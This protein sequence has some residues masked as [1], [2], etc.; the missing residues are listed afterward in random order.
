MEIINFDDVQEFLDQNTSPR[1]LLLG[2]GFSVACRPDIF[3]YRSLYDRVKESSGD[4]VE[5]AFDVLETHDFEAVIKFL[6]Q[7][8]LFQP[9]VHHECKEL[10]EQSQESAE[11]LK[12]LLISMIAVNHP[13]FPAEILDDEYESC[14]KFLSPFVSSRRPSA[15]IYTLNYDLLLYWTI[16]YS[17]DKSRRIFQADDGFRSPPEEHEQKYLEWSVKGGNQQRVHYLHGALHLLTSQ[18]RVLKYAW[19]RTGIRLLTQIE[20]ALNEDRF[21]L[22]V[23]E[24]D[25]TGKEE[26][27]IRN[28]YLHR[29]FRSFSSSLDKSDASLV[30]YGWSFSE[31][32]AHIKRV[33][34]NSSLKTI[35]ISVYGSPDSEENRM[36]FERVRQVQA[37]RESKENSVPLS[38]NYFNAESANIWGERPD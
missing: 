7:L 16:M 1:Y 12:E 4:F 24:G 10:G 35:F 30:T 3:N 33:I 26:K 18:T 38:V 17:L 20:A 29:A 37:W 13:E 28:A 11:R 36:L 5:D 21:P 23:A 31:S 9:R 15:S 22:F 19:N 25:S 8:A 32:D 27:I 6:K 2:N 14:A 34:V